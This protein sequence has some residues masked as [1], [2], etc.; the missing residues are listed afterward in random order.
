[1]PREA[2]LLCLL[3]GV[4]CVSEAAVFILPS[5]R[6]QSM[7]RKGGQRGK[8]CRVIST[9]S[10]LSLALSLSASLCLFSL[11]TFRGSN[12][13]HRSGCCTENRRDRM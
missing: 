5:A 3:T 4:Q 11:S 6:L 8:G 12:L 10:Q 2:C 7:F 1:M 9:R 13:I